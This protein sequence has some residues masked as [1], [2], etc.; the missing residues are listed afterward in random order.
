MMH[1]WMG[2]QEWGKQAMC[3][4]HIRYQPV[5]PSNLWHCNILPIFLITV[6]SG[7]VYLRVFD[8]GCVGTF[9]LMMATYLEQCSS[10]AGS[11]CAGPLVASESPPDLMPYALCKHKLVNPRGSGEKEQKEKKKKKEKVKEALRNMHASLTRTRACASLRRQN[12]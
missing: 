3:D 2:V 1:P 7:R 8:R 4:D 5:Y 12:I 10:S 9:Q 6:S 11:M